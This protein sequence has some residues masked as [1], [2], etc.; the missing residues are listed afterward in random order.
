MRLDTRTLA[1]MLIIFFT[2]SVTL[3]FSL[4]PSKNVEYY[5]K[6][7]DKAEKKLQACQ[8]AI[9]SAKGDIGAIEKIQNDKECI[10]AEDAIKFF[11]KLEEDKRIKQRKRSQEIEEKKY[12]SL[13][14]QYS[15]KTLNELDKALEKK[16][17]LGGFFTP[18][19]SECRAIE[20]ARK[21]VYKPTVKKLSLLSLEQLKK[22]AKN[23]SGEKY[24]QGSE[25]SA[26]EEARSILYKE[27]LELKKKELSSLSDKDI[28]KITY[29]PGSK[30][31]NVDIKTI[32]CEAVRQL[33]KDRTD[34]YKKFYLN[35]DQKRLEMYNKCNNE[36]KSIVR[37]TGSVQLDRRKRAEPLR[38][39]AVSF[40]RQQKGED[41]LYYSR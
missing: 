6:H 40:A 28:L 27:K 33:R 20:Q 5:K 32:Y 26:V 30:C 11:K 24:D 16:C 9:W 1:I 35:N 8:M 36:Y 37:T 2:P 25:C 3:S 14:T 13:I 31:Y 18:K 15:K 4:F 17:G 12:Q 10:A 21:I 22:R 7:K 34:S 39:I 19:Y 41:Y 29:G 23:C 38:C